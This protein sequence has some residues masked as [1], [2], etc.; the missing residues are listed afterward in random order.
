MANENLANWRGPLRRLGI[1]TLL[2]LSLLLLSH[3]DK[4]EGDSCDPACP[5]H[6]RCQDGICRDQDCRPPCREGR[7]CMRGACLRTCDPEGGA[8]CG[9]TETCCPDTMACV[10]TSID[11]DNCGGCGEACPADRSNECSNS[12]CGCRGYIAVPCG[13]DWGCCEDGC[14]DLQADPENC[15]ACGHDCGGLDCIAGE[16]RCSTDDPCPSDQECCD[17]GCKDVLTDEANCNRCG[18]AC[19]AGED[20]CG[21][22]CVNTLVEGEHCGDC[23]Q[24]CG[25]AESCCLGDCVN[26]S[27]DPYNCGDC[28]RDCGL[29]GSCSGGNCEQ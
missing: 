5:P 28:L 27:T 4:D 15:G 8:R 26:L 20:C 7:V 9:A 14:K 25:G 13:V 2:P 18:N 19:D 16:C 21:G 29:G 3:C 17:D 6:Q 24:A 23:G 10:D 12:S 1:T 11:F 22:Q